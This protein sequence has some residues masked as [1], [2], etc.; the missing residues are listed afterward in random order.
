[1]T[2]YD[3]DPKPIQT[4]IDIGAYDIPQLI[5]LVKQFRQVLEK[6]SYWYMYKQVNEGHSWGNWKANM[7]EYLEFFFPP[8]PS[9]VKSNQESLPLI[10]NLHY[11]LD[12]S[13][14]QLDFDL[15][16]PVK[17]LTIMLMDIQGKIL[18]ES[19]LTA[20]ERGQQHEAL[21]LD[22]PISSGA[23]FLQFRTDKTMF[24]YPVTFK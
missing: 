19:L 8:L 22:K 23:Y 2:G 3:S 14:I 9:S 12:S 11:V 21:L 7:N 4:Y 10:M 13:L 18:T 6:R 5:P 16:I 15:S 1:M 17:G 20:R 24:T